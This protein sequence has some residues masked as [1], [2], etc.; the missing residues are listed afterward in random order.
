MVIPLA[1][2]GEEMATLASRSFS[3][4]VPA[5]PRPF[6]GKHIRITWYLDTDLQA[7]T[8]EILVDRF[9]L[10]FGDGKGKRP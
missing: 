8:G 5:Y 1:A 3:L 6:R 2:R 9:Q 10:R 4:T 7:K